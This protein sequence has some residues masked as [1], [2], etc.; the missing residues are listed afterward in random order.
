M[1]KEEYRMTTVQAIKKLVDEIPNDKLA[2]AY[3]FIE[4]LNKQKNL[5]LKEENCA[6][7]SEPALAELWS[8]R[9]EDEFWKDL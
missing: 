1:D 2:I 3:D 7:L 8:N 4:Q 9:K 5:S 6:L